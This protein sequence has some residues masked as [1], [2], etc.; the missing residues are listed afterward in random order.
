MACLELTERLTQV[1]ALG[2]R[3]KKAQNVLRKFFTQKKGAEGIWA[4]TLD[5]RVS[6]CP[7]LDSGG[8]VGRL[9]PAW[10]PRAQ[11]V[12]LSLWAP[13]GATARGLSGRED[14]CTVPSASQ[15]QNES[16]G[17]ECLSAPG[18]N[19]GA[20]A[21]EANNPQLLTEKAK[22]IPRLL[23][24]HWVRLRSQRVCWELVS[25]PALRSAPPCSSSKTAPSRG[26]QS[27]PEPPE[28]AQPTH[29]SPALLG[30]PLEDVVTGE[31]GVLGETRLV[32]ELQLCG[33]GGRAG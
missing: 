17:M 8:S 4:F 25:R 20:L 11:A 16:L 10:L 7:G 26:Q 29:L 23:L 1:Q 31:V 19:T 32:P 21:M 24:G 33:T 28:P 30:G 3:V 12:L 22:M 15:R 14:E 5:R 6:V 18:L 9:R 2:S 13:A 27:R